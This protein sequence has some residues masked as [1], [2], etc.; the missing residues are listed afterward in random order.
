MTSKKLPITQ[1]SRMLE[2]SKSENSR[3]KQ[4]GR[5]QRHRKRK[6]NLGQ[7]KQVGRTRFECSKAATKSFRDKRTTC[8]SKSAKRRNR[9]RRTG[10][11]RTIRLCATT[12]IRKRLSY[13]FSRAI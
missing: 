13:R 8:F 4:R 6:I 7:N 11:V 9:A 3:K 12:R 1:R 10:V 2:W 5:K